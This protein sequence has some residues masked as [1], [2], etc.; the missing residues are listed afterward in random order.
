MRRFASN[1]IGIESGQRVLFDH[2]SY[3]T[4]MWTGSGA[5]QVAQSVT[6]SE[7]FLEVPDVTIAITMLDQH[8]E[9][10]LRIDVRAEDV[11][12]TGCTLIAEVWQDTRIARL[13]LAWRAIGP[14]ADPDEFWDV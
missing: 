12:V 3:P 5:R 6:F 13:R 1:Q 9:T 8:G 7:P 11:T 2:F 4:E 10:N 14:V